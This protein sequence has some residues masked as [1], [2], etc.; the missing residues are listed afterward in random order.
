VKTPIFFGC[1]CLGF[2]A[3]RPG[4]L[5]LKF[6][7]LSRVHSDLKDELETL[8]D[9][10]ENAESVVKPLA[11]SEERSSL[12]GETLDLFMKLS[13]AI[14]QAKESA[15]RIAES[16]IRSSKWALPATVSNIFSLRP[17]KDVEELK[18]YAIETC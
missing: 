16:Q 10:I 13:Q 15:K 1:F 18:A 6:W 4:F 8:Q 17:T 3:G 5:S 7:A 9:N 2:L 11:I 14:E 12:P